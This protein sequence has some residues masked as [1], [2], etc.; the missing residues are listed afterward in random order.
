MHPVKTVRIFLSS[1]CDVATEREQARDLLLGLARGPFVRGRVHIDVVS[2]DDP[3]GGATMDARLTPQQAVDRRL[4]T[5]AEC[6]LT[7]VVLW[8]RMGTPLTEKRA[9][10][11][12]AAA[13]TVLPAGYRVQQQRLQSNRGNRFAFQLLDARKGR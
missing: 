5:P 3:H 4:P 13:A 11:T 9:D 10:G 1:P 2:W 8:G 7:V 6:D 12:A